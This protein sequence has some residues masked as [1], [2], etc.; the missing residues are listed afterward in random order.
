M[1]RMLASRAEPSAGATP[2]R[3]REGRAVVEAVGA[4]RKVCPAGLRRTQTDAWFVGGGWTQHY[5][6]RN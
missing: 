4:G 3:R 1:L 5:G 6:D 2:G